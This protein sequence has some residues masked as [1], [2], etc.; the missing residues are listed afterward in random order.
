MSNHLSHGSLDGKLMRSGGPLFLFSSP[1]ADFIIP[2]PP[3]SRLTWEN[4]FQAL[5][6]PICDE[7]I[8][9]EYAVTH[10]SRAVH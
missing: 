10:A 5:I 1:D 4:A 8:Y 7:E 9:S 2:P 6:Q 3:V